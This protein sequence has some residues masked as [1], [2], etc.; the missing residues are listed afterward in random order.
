[1]SLETKQLITGSLPLLGVE[2]NYSLARAR[3]PE[4]T[5][6]EDALLRRVVLAQTVLV[7]LALTLK[8]Q[9]DS[10]TWQDHL[11]TTLADMGKRIKD[12]EAEGVGFITAGVIGLDLSIPQQSNITEITHSA[13]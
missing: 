5:D 3:I 10:A 6:E 11:E 13:A 4:L 7:Y 2:H 9:M 1:M 8:D 12:W